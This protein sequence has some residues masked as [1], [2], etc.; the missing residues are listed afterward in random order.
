[1][2]GDTVIYIYDDYAGTHSTALAAAY[3]LKKLPVDRKL[4]KEEILHVDYFNKLTKADFGKIFF[5]GI[6]EDGNS[7]YTI[8]RKRSK[9]VIPA[10]ENLSVVLQEKYNDHERIIFSN[11]SPTVPLA[12]TMGGFFSRGLNIDFIGVPLLILGAKQCCHDILRVVEYTKQT[13]KLTNERVIVLDNKN[14]K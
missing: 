13:A 2:K 7:V 4:T 14:M 1:M 5:H 9:L 10:L 12:M 8:G 3:H 11:T 6:D